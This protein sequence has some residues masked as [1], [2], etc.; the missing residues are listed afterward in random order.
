MVCHS[1][2]AIQA[3]LI[4]FYWGFSDALKVEHTQLPTRKK[5]KPVQPNLRCNTRDL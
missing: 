4:E 1:V 5:N 3:G 2:Y